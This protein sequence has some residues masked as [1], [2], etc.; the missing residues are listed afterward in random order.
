MPLCLSPQVFTALYNSDDNI[1]LAAPTGSGKTICAEFAVMRML[2]THASEDGDKKFGGRCVYVAPLPQIAHERFLEWQERFGRQLQ[3][4]VRVAELTGES[5]TDLKILEKSNI[6]VSTPERWDQLSRRW[7]QRKPV[8]QVCT[9]MQ[10][11]KTITLNDVLSW[12]WQRRPS[13][14]CDPC[15]SG[16][17]D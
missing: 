5:A 14:A 4:S 16:C 13:N 3:G 12:S 15:V 1:L 11:K 2:Q 10:V 17:F 7:K 6:V 9:V 8:Q